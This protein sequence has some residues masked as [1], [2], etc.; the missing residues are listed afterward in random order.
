LLALFTYVC[1]I[2]FSTLMISWHL[3]RF[4]TANLVTFKRN[5]DLIFKLKFLCREKCQNDSIETFERQRSSVRP[6]TFSNRSRSKNTSQTD[7]FFARWFSL[8]GG[9]IHL[10]S[11]IRN[12]EIG[13]SKVSISCVFPCNYRIA[14]FVISSNE[15]AKI[16]KKNKVQFSSHSA[17]KQ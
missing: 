12:V 3:P 5:A 11:K 17:K 16:E 2:Q 4:E 10:F 9:C 13:T 8:F 6:S 15:R 1:P 7:C 14:I